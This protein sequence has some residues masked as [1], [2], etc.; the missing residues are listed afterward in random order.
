MFL[1]FIFPHYFFIL[2]L[3]FVSLYIVSFLKFIWSFNFFPI[4][5]LFFCFSNFSTLFSFSFFISS[6]ALHEAESQNK[7]FSRS[8]QELSSIRI[9]L[10]GERD[11]AFSEL[12]DSRELIRDLQSRLD[13]SNGSVNQLKSDF[14]LRL[15]EKEDELEGIR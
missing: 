4:F 14:E 11:S 1:Y 5:S 6:D 3:Y 15:R 8:V 7:D 12:G 2:I 10:T 9:Q 13:A